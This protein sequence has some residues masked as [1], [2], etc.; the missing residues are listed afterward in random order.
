MDGHHNEVVASEYRRLRTI[1][2]EKGFI[3]EYRADGCVTWR[4]DV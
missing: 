2:G 3:V 1:E 4:G